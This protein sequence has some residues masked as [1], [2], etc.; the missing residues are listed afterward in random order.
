MSPLWRGFAG[1][2]VVF[3]LAF[4]VTRMEKRIEDEYAL[5]STNPHTA[6]NE[7]HAND[8]CAFYLVWI[9]RYDKEGKQVGYWFIPGE[10]DITA[11]ILK[12]YPQ[13]IYLQN[14]HGPEISLDI[15]RKNRRARIW[16]ADFNVQLSKLIEQ[17]ELNEVR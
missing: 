3:F 8:E 11:D 15:E 16:A 7:A 6:A 2:I 5:V 9:N 17:D 13:R 4:Y 10:K 14:T 1:L 12:E